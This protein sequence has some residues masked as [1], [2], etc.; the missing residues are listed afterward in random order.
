[1]QTAAA[2]TQ[3]NADLY[4][5]ADKKPGLKISPHILDYSLPASVTSTCTKTVTV[6]NIQIKVNSAN[7][8]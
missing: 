2:A 6:I 8:Q 3:F 4:R 5:E 7:S 1:M